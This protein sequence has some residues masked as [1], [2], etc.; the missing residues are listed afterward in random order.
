MAIAE[1]PNIEQKE[2]EKLK[3]TEREILEKISME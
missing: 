3:K 1:T 2:K